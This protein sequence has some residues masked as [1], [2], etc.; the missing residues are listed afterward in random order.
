M[1]RG[2]LRA[3]TDRQL[4]RERDAIDRSGLVS[5]VLVSL[6]TAAGLAVLERLVE[7]LAQGHV[8]LVLRAAKQNFEPNNIDK[9]LFTVQKLNYQ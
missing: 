2:V 1:S 9:T 7:R 8:R 4:S 5:F 6:S 3:E